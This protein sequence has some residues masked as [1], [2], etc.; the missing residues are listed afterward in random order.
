MSLP[1]VMVIFAVLPQVIGMWQAHGNDIMGYD[2]LGPAGA[3][4]NAAD[5]SIAIRD[6]HT[7]TGNSTIT[8]D[9]VTIETGG[10]LIITNVFNLADGAGDDLLVNGMLNLQDGSLGNTGTIRIAMSG[11][12]SITTAN[13]K[14]ILDPVINDGTIQW[15]AGVVVTYANSS[16][17]ITN[18]GTFTITGNDLFQD[19]GGTGSITN[20][21]TINK[22]NAGTTT[23]NNF[24]F[25]NPGIINIQA[26]TIALGGSGAF[27]NTNVITL[28]SA[29]MTS[30]ATFNHNTGSLIQGTGSV[31]NTGTL[32]LNIDLLFPSG[33]T[34]TS[35]GT[36]SV[37]QGSGNLTI[38]NDFSIEGSI[39]GTGTLIVNA[40]TTWPSGS[41]DR[42]FTNQMGRTLTVN[43]TFQV[44]LEAPLVNEGTIIWQ[45]GA[46]VLFANEGGSFTNNSTFSINNNNFF[47]DNGGVGSISN[48]GTINKTS[49]GTTTFNNFNFSNPGIINIQA[50]TIAL[51]GLGAFTNTNIITLTSANMTSAATFNHS[52]GSLIQGTGSFINIG[53]LNLNIDLLFPSGIT[54]ASPGTG[55]VIQGSG[56]LTI[57]ND[58]SI[59]GTIQ[60]VGTL[61]VNGN[62]TWP[63]GALDRT[64][65][66]QSSRTLTLNSTFQVYLEAPL[67]NNGNIIWQDGNLVLFA[68]EGS[69]LPTTVRSLS[70]LTNYFKTTVV[71]V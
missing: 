34:F 17:S 62:T 2:D 51:G 42:T 69:S 3:A 65:T 39:Q 70:T 47:Q 59:Q 40:N 24:N 48:N 46:I 4:P 57:N 58:F 10:T 33:L 45:D 13:Q 12:F 16:T 15:Q 37:I 26:G 20:N 29:N 64:F 23:F 31:T 63:S 8:A 7:V 36:G 21:G 5:G 68:N 32:N 35:P 54:F 25:S 27:T 56:N 66:N 19:N 28:T 38:N 9:Q 11:L 30:A 18:N 67:V 49:A 60:G 14:S 50:G 53:T 55:S 52:T 43:S 1:K 61:N 22:T 41:L 71:S 44:Y 6:P